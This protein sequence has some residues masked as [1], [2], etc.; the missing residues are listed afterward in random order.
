MPGK[1]RKGWGSAQAR[2]NGRR[3]R[4]HKHFPGL[5][6]STSEP[7]QKMG[8]PHLMMNWKMG[9]TGHFHVYCFRRLRLIIFAPF[10]SDSVL[11]VRWGSLTDSHFLV[12]IMSPWPASDSPGVWCTE[13]TLISDLHSATH[14]R[15]R[16]PKTIPATDFWEDT[17]GPN[18]PPFVSQDWKLN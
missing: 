1:W 6:W 7:S 11:N 9:P 18:Q 5:I 13:K 10:F 14:L 12:R 2:E 8:H 17:A 15:L 3:L 16:S 4:N